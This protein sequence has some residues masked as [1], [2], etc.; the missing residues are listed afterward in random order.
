MNGG[1]LRLTWR[2]LCFH[3]A[4]SLILLVCLAL[5]FLL[6][7]YL[8]LLIRAYESSLTQRAENTPLVLGPRGNEFELVLRSL[9]FL[10][11]E[12]GDSR[13]NLADQQ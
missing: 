12:G 3:R 8:H 1:L 6:P 7:V 13:L 9:Y 2:Y 4:R 11:H 10:S 5:A